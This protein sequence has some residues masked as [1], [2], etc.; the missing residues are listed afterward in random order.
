MDSDTAKKMGRQMAEGLL[1]SAAKD[2][3]Q[4]QFRIHMEIAEATGVSI[5][6]TLALNI[7]HQDGVSAK[8]AVNQV[9]LL[10]D[11]EL[12]GMLATPW[13]IQKI[14]ELK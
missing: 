8:E 3:S 13:N 4:E 12:Q 10:I 5:L 14:G 1:R 7:H 6:A 11:K 9:K 2:C